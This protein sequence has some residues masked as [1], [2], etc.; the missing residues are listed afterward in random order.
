MAVG[1]ADRPPAATGRTCD[2]APTWFWVGRSL[3]SAMLVSPRRIRMRGHP[4]RR[5]TAGTEGGWLRADL[6]RS[7]PPSAL[8][9]VGS[10]GA[11]NKLSHRLISL[12]RR[13]RARFGVRAVLLHESS[14]FLRA[15][16][17][18]YRIGS[19]PRHW[20]RSRSTNCWGSRRLS[21]E[22]GSSL[23]QFG[24]RAYRRPS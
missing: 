2:E 17:D 18:D 21:V 23:R 4:R 12:A 9:T 1:V 6:D 15:G 13:I 11:K 19:S 8:R 24:S 14:W 20:S 3:R 22:P 16:S 7:G 5:R 10:Y